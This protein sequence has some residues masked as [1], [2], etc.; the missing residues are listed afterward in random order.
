MKGLRRFWMFC[1]S[2]MLMALIMPAVF[3]GCIT[4]TANTADQT[5]EA[6]FKAAGNN[7]AYYGLAKESDADIT[8]VEAAINA[9]IEILSKTD[10]GDMVKL[11]T[12]YITAHQ[13]PGYAHLVRSA[14]DLL[15][16]L[17]II[18][19]EIPENQKRAAKLIQIF[20]D[21]AAD[22]IKDLRADRK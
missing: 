18:N 15:N 21:G 1:M 12:D 7:L 14:T 10:T 3:S 19:L 4:F 22:G 5:Q 11:I 2:G 6:L 17:V 13:F 8:K 16:G 9:A 20:L